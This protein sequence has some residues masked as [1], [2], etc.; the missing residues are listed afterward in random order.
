MKYCGVKLSSV[1]ISNTCLYMYMYVPIA[2]TQLVYHTLLQ[3]LDQYLVHS[4]VTLPTED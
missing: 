3:L 1:T 4:T 2:Y